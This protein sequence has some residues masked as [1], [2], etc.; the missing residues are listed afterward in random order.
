M[1]QDL[2]IDQAKLTR[3]R[4][5]DGINAVGV[6]LADAVE[7][8]GVSSTFAPA[9]GPLTRLLLNET[10]FSSLDGADDV[11]RRYFLY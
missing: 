6:T 9:D 7:R 1:K 5:E 3:P 2:Q 4:S 10:C 8:L 11:M